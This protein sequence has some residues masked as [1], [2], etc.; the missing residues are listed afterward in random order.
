M[1][2]TNCGTQV[3]D[4]SAFCTTCGSALSPAAA[5]TPPPAAPI[6]AVA[7]TGQ[8]A[9]PAAEPVSGQQPGAMG[10]AEQ[11]NAAAMRLVAEE[12]LAEALETLNEAVRLAPNHAPSYLNRADVL[13]R[14]GMMSQA[15]ADRRMAAQLSPASAGPVAGTMQ[16][17]AG[18]V[19]C[20]SCGQ[21]APA[22]ARFC[23]ACAKD[24]SGVEYA[25]FWMRFAANF[26]DALILMIPNIVLVLAVETPASNL[27]SIAL[28][29]VYLVGFWST[30]GATPG[31]M[32]LGIKITTVDG[33]PIDFGR[34]FLRYIGYWASAITLGI[35]HLMIA[36]TGQKRG[37]HD[38]IAGTVVIK[39][40]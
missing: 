33:E 4:D 22:S 37:L 7:P 34:A 9:A 32:A 13:A 36:F 12:K 10:A 3:P 25:G 18:T 40:R 17:A 24:M 31:K 28:G 8:D 26:I 11:K 30:Q 19:A 29:L 27:L 1:F 2:C 20:P 21:S 15:D 14:L 23:P 16:P 5:T 39:T 35:G 6:S 38:Y